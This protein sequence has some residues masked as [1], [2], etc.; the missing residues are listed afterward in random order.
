MSTLRAKAMFRSRPSTSLGDG[1]EP[2]GEGVAAVVTTTS[3][4]AHRTRRESCLAMRPRP[5]AP[6]RRAMSTGM[7]RVVAAWYSAYGGYAATA[8]SHHIAFSSP[9]T[10]RAT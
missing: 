2:L 1:V 8:R 9:V 10:S 6:A 3:M 4:A 7:T 5:Y